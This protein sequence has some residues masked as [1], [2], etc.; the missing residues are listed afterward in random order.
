MGFMDLG[1]VPR[2]SAGPTGW[3]RIYAI[4]SPNR[5]T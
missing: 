5:M 3:K 1:E 2:T 4:L